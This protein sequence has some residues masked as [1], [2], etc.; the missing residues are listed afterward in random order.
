M[1]LYLVELARLFQVLCD[2]PCVK[3][4]STLCVFIHPR[5]VKEAAARKRMELLVISVKEG[6][7]KYVT[8]FLVKGR[9]FA[10]VSF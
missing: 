8:S 6:W 4:L 5:C 10:V 9:I 7:I 2:S 3:W 1:S